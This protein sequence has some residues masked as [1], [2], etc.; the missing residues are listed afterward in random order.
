MQNFGTV[1]STYLPLEVGVPHLQGLAALPPRST[2][3]LFPSDLAAGPPLLLAACPCP[4]GLPWQRCSPEVGG[5]PPQPL[6]GQPIW[7]IWM[8][9]LGQHSRVTSPGTLT[10]CFSLVR[11]QHIMICCCSEVWLAPVILFTKNPPWQTI[12]FK[13]C[14]HIHV[15]CYLVF[16]LEVALVPTAKTYYYSSIPWWGAGWLP[17]KLCLRW[18]G[19]LP[20]ACARE[21]SLPHCCK[22]FPLGHLLLQWPCWQQ[23]KQAKLHC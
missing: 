6:C 14:C 8:L 13:S 12:F 19:G 21:A 3:L 11:N 2:N 18:V 9:T 7:Q 10:R 17:T 4:G 1:K 16:P 22:W 15:T 23:P 20:L 5:V